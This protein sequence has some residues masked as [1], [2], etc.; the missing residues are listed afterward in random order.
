MSLPANLRSERILASKQFRD[1]K[2]RNT[3]KTAPP[4]KMSTMRLLGRAIFAGRDRLPPAP[5]PISSP[6]EHWLKLPAR[7]S[8][9]VTWLGHSSLLLESNG[10]RILTDPVFGDRV[11]PVSFAGPKRLHPAPVSVSQLP[12][13]DAVLISHDHFD[14]LCRPTVEALAKLKVPIVT[15]LGVGRHLEM[16]GVEPSRITELD[17]WEEHVLFGGDLSF[18]ATPAQHFSGRSLFDRNQTLWSSWV[19]R[20]AEHRIFFSGD[21][22]L[23]PELGGVGERFGPF[24]LTM[25]EV[26]AWHP[27]WGDIHLG[28]ENALR[29]FDLLGGGTLLPVHWG[30]FDLGLHAWEEPVETL[31]RLAGPAKVLTPTLGRPF[32]PA[33]LEGPTPWWRSLRTDPNTERPPKAPLAAMG[34]LPPL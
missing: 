29:A 22:G 20:T 11:S 23:T 30:T 26:G 2:F 21:T 32:E 10:L 31:L 33:Q 18:T 9:R 19:I 6:L 13:L 17:W 8:L 5:P 3:F 7:Q 12:P 25:L 24:D 1:G 28:P 14:H 15:S 16:F 27:A 4:V 34:H